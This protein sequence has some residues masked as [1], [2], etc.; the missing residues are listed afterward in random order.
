MDTSASISGSG[1]VLA[2]GN[3]RFYIDSSADFNSALS[4]DSGEV[5]EL[6]ILQ[7]YVTVFKNSVTINNN[8]RLNINYNCYFKNNLTIN[9]GGTLNGQTVNYS[10]SSIVHNGIICI[11]SFNYNT[12]CSVQGSGQWTCS[13]YSNIKPGVTLTLQSNITYSNGF[14][15]LNRMEFWI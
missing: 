12:S 9:S 1:S 5:S 4:I 3:I 8:A 2:K 10:G 13:N 14:L 15:K 7:P 11:S 6:H